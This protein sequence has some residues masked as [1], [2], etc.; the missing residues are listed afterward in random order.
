TGLVLTDS[1]RYVSEVTST[2]ISAKRKDVFE[3]RK[4][5]VRDAGNGQPEFVIHRLDRT[6]YSL[7]PERMV[8]FLRSKGWPDGRPLAVIAS[9]ELDM[10]GSESAPSVLVMRAWA[11]VGRAANV[12]VFAAPADVAV[13]WIGGFG[14][15]H[16]SVGRSRW[17]EV[18]LPAGLP[19]P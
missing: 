3:V 8:D 9:R 18:F 14:V 5:T 19:A 11:G 17:E 13:K 16:A 12:A 6:S 15:G 7:S 1:V 4:A 10:A 2:A